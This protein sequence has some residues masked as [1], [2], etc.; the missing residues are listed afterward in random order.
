VTHFPT[1]HP[2]QEVAV[3]WLQL[4][5]S[6]GKH[7]KLF[8]DDMGLGKTGAAITAARRLKLKRVLVIGPLA[9]RPVW[10]AEWPRF[11]PGSSITE[12]ESTSQEIPETGHVV[13]TFE[14]VRRRRCDLFIYGKWDI[15]IDEWH[16]IRG[17][18]AARTRAIMH[19]TEGLAARCRRI[20]A[21]TGTPL[22]NHAG[23]LYPLLRLAGVYTGSLDSFYRRFCQLYYDQERGELKI[24]GVNERNL[25]ELHAMLDESGIVLRRLKGNEMPHL[26]PLVHEYVDVSKGEV[27]LEALFPE[28]S[29]SDQMVELVEMV[30]QQR[31]TAWGVL[32]PD[33]EEAIEEMSFADG[34]DVLSGLSES[35]SEL[36]KLTGMQKVAGV[37]ELVREELNAGLYPK[38]FIITRHTM[39]G[40]A[41]EHG[42]QEFGPVRLYGGSTPKQRKHMID[43]FTHDWECQVFIGQ[44]RA[45]GPSVNLTARGEC[46]ET[47]MVEQSAV[48]GENN[49]AL[50]RNHRIGATRQ[51]RARIV[52]L[53]DPVDTRWETL[54]HQKNIHIAKTMREDLFLS[55]EFDPIG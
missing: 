4:P 40:E 21:L 27:D 39:V 54:V 33:A 28:W 45:C 42:L 19:P 15:I 44:V 51:V 43:K 38:L 5:C 50:A 30:N 29:M 41:L 8:A 53:D 6:T 3:E 11:W 13:C 26:P 24:V 17:P 46:Y 37:I 12:M 2:W 35:S 9:A 55:K 18:N 47:L 7:V 52:R 48:P 10:A 16:D 1:L 34:L 49:Q 36:L 23:E 14:F 22:A 31:R 25:P 20:W 32:D